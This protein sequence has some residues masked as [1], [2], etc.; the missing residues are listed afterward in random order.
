M[1]VGRRLG[2]ATPS[3]SRP[4]RRI[5]PRPRYPRNPRDRAQKRGLAA[6]RRPQ[7]RK[8]TSPARISAEMPRKRVVSRRSISAHPPERDDGSASCPGRGAWCWLWF[9]LW[10]WL[11][12]SLASVSLS[13]AR[14]RPRRRK[15]FRQ[16]RESRTDRITRMVPSAMTTGSRAG[17]AATAPRGRP[18]ASARCPKGRRR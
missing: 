5:T 1:L 4:S 2:G 6:A 13:P 15:G 7:Q 16:G 9:W 14:F 18:A 12:G 11:T 17:K 10:L 3:M 8:R